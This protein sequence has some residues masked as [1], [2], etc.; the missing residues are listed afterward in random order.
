MLGVCAV[1]GC[2]GT[3]LVVQHE[4]QCAAYTQVPRPLHLEPVRLLSGGCPVPLSRVRA[5]SPYRPIRPGW[6][7]EALGAGLRLGEG[8]PDPSLRC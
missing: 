8:V 2:G 1:S 5:E 7:L 3:H 6:G 4:E